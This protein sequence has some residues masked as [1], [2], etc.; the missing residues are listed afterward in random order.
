[1]P[2]LFILLNDDVYIFKSVPEM[3]EKFKFDE[4]V[5]KMST[6]NTTQCYRCS[7]IPFLPNTHITM[8]MIIS[9]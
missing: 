7:N 4:F 2:R 3:D 1:M 9:I 6:H 5:M 8:M